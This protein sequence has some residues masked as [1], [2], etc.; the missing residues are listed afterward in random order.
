MQ[1][2]DGHYTIVYA[3]GDYRTLR[4]NK[5]KKIKDEKGEP[6]TVASF[7]QGREYAGFGFLLPDNKVRFWKK[8][9]V[10]QGNVATRLQRIQ[11]AVDIIVRDP[12]A[13][14]MA[15]A[16][17]EKACAKCGRDLTVPASLHMGL[18]PECAG[19]DRWNKQDHSAAFAWA[20]GRALVAGTAKA[21]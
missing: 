8:F 16:L 10:A 7:K 14:Q 1:I 13:A 4:F 15:F 18:G 19:K 12:Q 20:K 5:S 21:A 6:M 17:H 2:Q 3:N 11:R 9:R